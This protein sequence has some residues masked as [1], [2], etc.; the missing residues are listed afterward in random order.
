MSPKW[1]IFLITTWLILAILGGVIEGAYVG[2]GAGTEQTVLNTLMNCKVMTSTTIWGKISGVFTD[3]S[4][5]W[6]MFKV[7]TFDFVFF[8]GVWEIV[9]WVFFL[10]IAIAIGTSLILAFVRGV[11]SS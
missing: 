5:F 8:T 4:F 6:A 9:R 2:T 3:S 11:G 10:P 1:I 7:L